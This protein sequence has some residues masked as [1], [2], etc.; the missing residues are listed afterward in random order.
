M[1]GASHQPAFMG[2][3]LTISHTFLPSPPS[4]WVIPCLLCPDMIGLRLVLL[5]F[6]G[7]GEYGFSTVEVGAILGTGCGIQGQDYNA[8]L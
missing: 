4:R 6:L 1:R 5:T 7:C 3:C 8:L 2:N